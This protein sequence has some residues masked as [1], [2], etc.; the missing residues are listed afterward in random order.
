MKD[1]MDKLFA[2]A[3]CV[4]GLAL[5]A[6]AQEMSEVFRDAATSPGG[7]MSFAT[8]L[9]DEAFRTGD[10]TEVEAQRWNVQGMIVQID[11]FRDKDLLLADVAK[12]LLPPAERGRAGADKGVNAAASYAY[13]EMLDS[14][15]RLYDRPDL[16]AR[17]ASMRE[18]LKAKGFARPFADASS[19]RAALAARVRDELAHEIRPGGVGGQEFWN[20]NAQMFMYPPSFSF[21][22]VKG[23]VRYRFQ[24]MD[25]Q[26][27]AH[28][29]EAESPT[30]SLKPVWEFVPRGLIAVFCFGLGGDGEVCGLAG[31]RRFWKKA[32]FE[33][34][35][36]PRAKRPYAEAQKMLCEYILNLP[37]V[38]GLERDGHPDLA[39]KSNFTSYPSKMQSALIRAMLSLAKV[40]PEKRERA[41]KVARISA[42]YL[43][44]KSQ[45]AGTPLEYFTPTYEGE[46]Q[47]SGTY[48]GMHMLIYPA[49]AG[50]ALVNLGE[51][52]G[53]AKYLDAARRIAE[54]Y[55]R[56]QGEDGTWFLKM[57]E[58]DGKP[59]SDN[60]L[61]P[62]SDRKSVV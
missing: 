4:M 7:V 23:A 43:I 21:Q 10:R 31:Q 28:V 33:P 18:A 35:V 40:A 2:I 39:Q 47:L 44:E 24:A 36:Y 32:P 49:D 14:A 30:A 27:Y 19:E 20:G 9:E 12:W 56:L 42:D 48:S 17:A 53:E 6:A 61:V 1:M 52:T 15:A 11:R 60:R 3:A 5:A 16:A 62:T 13:A 46:G 58:K 37:E 50:A 45:K 26:Q 51:A 22:K 41:L 59:A 34:G 54:T 8:A 38:A 25:D 57:Y 29:F 55:I